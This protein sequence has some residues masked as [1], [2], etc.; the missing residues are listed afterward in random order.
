MKHEFDLMKS[1]FSYDME[2]VA[3]ELQMEFIDLQA[4]NTLKNSFDNWPLI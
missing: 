2:T 3:D 1:P 4:D